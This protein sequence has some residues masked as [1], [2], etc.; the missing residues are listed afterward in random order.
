MSRNS[1]C[2][3]ERSNKTST[4]RASQPE[5]EGD[6]CAAHRQGSPSPKIRRTPQWCPKKEQGHRVDFRAF[7]Q[8]CRPSGTEPFKYTWC[9]V[10]A[11]GPKSQRWSTSAPVL[12]Y[13]CD[14]R[15]TKRSTP[16]GTR[17]CYGLSSSP[18]NSVGLSH[19]TKA[20]SR[21]RCQL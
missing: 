13:S 14:Y 6:R 10:L 16:V 20:R 7:C 12:R 11:A 17:L 3:V 19:G 18:S 2:L 1:G 9:S 15:P 4:C 21:R 8:G 5:C